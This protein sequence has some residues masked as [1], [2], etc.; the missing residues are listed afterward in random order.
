MDDRSFASIFFIIGTVRT[1]CKLVCNCFACMPL[2]AHLLMQVCVVSCFTVVL[3][4]CTHNSI[5]YLA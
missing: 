2:C 3:V 4:F 1:S 5:S